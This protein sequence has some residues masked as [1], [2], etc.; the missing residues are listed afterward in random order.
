MQTASQ[1]QY[2]LHA[3]CD[4]TSYLIGSAYGNIL[5]IRDSSEL[6]QNEK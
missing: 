6:T 3:E 1:S 2:P 4:C 5:L